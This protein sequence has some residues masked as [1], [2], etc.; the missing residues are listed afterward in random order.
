MRRAST[1]VP[2]C[3]SEQ[4]QQSRAQSADHGAPEMVYLCYFNLL[5]SQ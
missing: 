4:D 3:E 5:S 2:A 1:L